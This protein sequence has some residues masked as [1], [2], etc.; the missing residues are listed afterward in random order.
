M[1]NHI[2]ANSGF[3]FN[4]SFLGCGSSV[5]PSVCGPIPV[6]WHQVSP[7]NRHIHAQSDRWI[8]LIRER[9]FIVLIHTSSVMNDTHRITVY[10]YHILHEIISYRYLL[11]LFSKCIDNT[12]VRHRKQPHASFNL[13]LQWNGGTHRGCIEVPDLSTHNGPCCTFMGC[14]AQPTPWR[15]FILRCWRSYLLC[16]RRLG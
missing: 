8:Q 10:T 4:S 15:R 1:S 11:K 5:R 7:Y 9:D 6:S 16:S 3:L 14:R 13:R 12:V 2:F